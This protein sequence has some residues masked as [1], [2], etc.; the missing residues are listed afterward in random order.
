MPDNALFRASNLQQNHH[1][2]PEALRRLKNVRDY[3]MRRERDTPP[4][5]GWR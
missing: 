1:A 2:A 5:L 4:M 3:R